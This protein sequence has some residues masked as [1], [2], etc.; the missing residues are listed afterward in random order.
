MIVLNLQREYFQGRIQMHVLKY[1]EKTSSF[2]SIGTR[3]CLNLIADVLSMHFCSDIVYQIY[4][5]ILF[6]FISDKVNVS[7]NFKI[8]GKKETSWVFKLLSIQTEDL[9]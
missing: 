4:H 2:G 5:V 6:I 3:L 1:W 9:L 7:H 8:M